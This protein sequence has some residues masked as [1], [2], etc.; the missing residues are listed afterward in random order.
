MTCTHRKPVYSVWQDVEIGLLGETE[1]QLIEVGGE[2]TDIAAGIGRFR[3]TQCGRIGYYTG[4]WRDY[5][6]KGI[7]CPGSDLAER[8]GLIG[9]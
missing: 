5:Y 4:L 3:C 1:Q 7:P 8:D 2:S 6:E 9:R